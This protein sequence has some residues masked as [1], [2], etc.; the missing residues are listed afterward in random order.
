MADDTPPP[1]VRASVEDFLYMRPSP[2]WPAK[3]TWE[4]FLATI[5]PTY[6]LGAMLLLGSVFYAG[7]QQKEWLPH[8]TPEDASRLLSLPSMA[9]FAAWMGGAL[10]W[11]RL[12]DRRGR[13]LPFLASA[14]MTLAVGALTV[15]SPS[16]SAYIAFRALLGFALSGQAALSFVLTVEW[17]VRADAS[18]LTLCANALFSLG[19]LLLVAV[20]AAGNAYGF[21]WR[22]Q[23][24]ICCSCIFAFLARGY[25]RTRESP[26]FLVSVGRHHDAEATLRDA[27]AKAGQRVPDEMSLA[28]AAAADGGAAAEEDDGGGALN[29]QTATGDLRVTG[30]RKPWWA[31][32][33]SLHPRTATPARATGAPSLFERRWLLR[34]LCVSFSW[35]TVNLLF[36][37]LDFAVASCDAAHGCDIYR[38]GALTAIADLPGYAVSYVAADSPRFGRRLTLSL[39]F[40]IAGAALLAICVLKAGLGVADDVGVL[41]VLAFVGK[42]GAASAFSVAYIYPTELFPPQIRTSA[43]GVANVFG[44]LAAI[45]APLAPSLAPALLYSILGTLGLV[46]GALVLLLPETRAAERAPTATVG[47]PEAVAA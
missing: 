13:R 23:E 10:L 39:S 4:A 32:R 34:V 38:H 37:G 45:L 14:W 5:V 16:L 30:S 2:K 21:D 43:L 36:Y 17:A 8:A 47:A 12:A 33:P 26:Q 29:S 27:L 24:L 19:N 15:L 9:M 42:C 28:P 41:G 22:V 18:L 31:S 25:A 44:R 20:A 6:S 35:L 7:E 3:P 40:S 1:I 11:A 46:N